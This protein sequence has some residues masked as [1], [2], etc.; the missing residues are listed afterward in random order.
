MIDQRPVGVAKEQDA[1]THLPGGAHG[2]HGPAFYMAGVAVHHQNA[3]A[4]VFRQ[5]L[6]LLQCA[7]VAVA[8]HGLH[9]DGRVLPVQ[10][11]RVV[12]TVA[13]MQND[14]RLGTLHTADHGVHISMGIRQDQNAHTS[15]LTSDFK[16]KYYS[17]HLL[18]IQIQS[19]TINTGKQG[20][21]FMQPGILQIDLHGKNRY[22]ARVTVD[23]ALR[24]AGGGTYR[25]RCIHGYH[26]GSALRDMLRE[27]YGKHPRVLRLETGLG[28][29]STDLVL[30]EF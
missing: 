5:H 17:R 23:A 30:R 1:G 20:V 27:E 25:I 6:G 8:G 4:A 24:R 3:H 18:K 16:R 26:G 14:V 11:L 10:C 28:P 22:Q 12:K 29:G 19:F 21:V 13:Q 15:Y 2:G 9:G 7:P